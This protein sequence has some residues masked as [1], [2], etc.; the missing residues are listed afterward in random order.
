ML[1]SVGCSRKILMTGILT[2][3]MTIHKRLNRCTFEP[4]D[5]LR[6]QI[7]PTNVAYAKG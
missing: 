7:S 2:E 1:F 3:R 4:P 6:L 5:L